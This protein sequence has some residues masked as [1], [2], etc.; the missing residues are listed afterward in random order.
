MPTIRKEDVLSKIPSN[1]FRIDTIS[2]EST[3]ITLQC[4]WLYTTCNLIQQDIQKECNRILNKALYT[5]VNRISK[6]IPEGKE[7]AGGPLNDSLPS[8]TFLYDGLHQLGI[9]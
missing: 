4:V 1:L 3:I 2:S 8:I 6:Y 9:E 5:E 7:I